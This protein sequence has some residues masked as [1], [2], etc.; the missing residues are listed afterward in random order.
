[1]TLRFAQIHVFREVW[2]AVPHGVDLWR[3]YWTQACA[4]PLIRRAC[5]R[6]ARA[7]WEGGPA[8]SVGR[9]PEHES[10]PD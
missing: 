5:A 8:G 10:R 2:P 9:R 4:R 6:C 1:M 7:P 3:R